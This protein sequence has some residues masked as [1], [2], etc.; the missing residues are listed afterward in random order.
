M[1]ERGSGGAHG[2]PGP[3][4]SQRPVRWWAGAGLFLAAATLS[5]TVYLRAPLPEDDPLRSTLVVLPLVAAAL[6]GIG[7]WAERLG[8]SRR[9]ARATPA[10]LAGVLL[11]TVLALGRSAAGWR[12][13]QA[14]A[15]VL[16]AAFCLLLAVRV[17]R[18]IVALRPA[19]GATPPR[20]PSGLFFLLPLVVY[21]A[22]LPWSTEQRPPDGDEPWYLLI[23]HS[24]AYDFDSRLSNNY[25]QGDSLRFLDRR[26]A[27]QL[28]DPVAEDG[29]AY[30]RHNLTL[31][32][33]LALPY[34]VAGK[35]GALVVMAVLAAAL[36]RETLRLARHYRPVSPRAALLVWAI[37]AFT[38]P[39]LL[40]S[41]QVWVEVP[42]AL[43]LV[44]ALERIH[45]L[46]D[47]EA[48]GLAGWLVLGGCLIAL[49][50]LK[51]RLAFLG[52]VLMAL[53][54]LAGLR[55]LRRQVLVLVGGFALASA[56]V[57][58]VNQILFGNP[59]R[60]YSLE[61][62]LALYQVPPLAYLRGLGGFFF[63]GA[64]G[65][66]P[67]APIWLLLLV[68]LLTAGRHRRLLLDVGMLCLPYLGLFGPH[69]G[70]FGGWSPPFRYALVTLPL[71]AIL[72]IPAL[73]ES[74][75]RGRRGALS[76]LVAL[77]GAL[78]LVWLALPGWTYNLAD[79]RSHLLDALSRLLGA[80]VARFFASYIW[81]RPA[82]WIWPLAAVAAAL[83][84]RWGPRWRRG[85]GRWGPAVALGA[86]ALLPVAAE[87]V[88]SRV[89]ELEDP[90]VAKNGGRL[91][92]HRWT[93]NR[94]RLRSGWLLG[95]GGRVVAPL[96]P[97]G[98]TLDLTVELGVLRPVPS[99]ELLIRQGEELRRRLPLESAGWRSVE[100]GPLPW[101]AGEPLVL[102]VDASP[103]ATARP[104][105]VLDRARLRWLPPQAAGVIA[106]PPARD[107]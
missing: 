17:V 40:Y 14:A 16:F 93:P 31:P 74:Q 34:R 49:P 56:T 20:N 26:L 21:L 33:L 84:W 89:V 29:E 63:D 70:W 91:H 30:S 69:T 79:G 50:L 107:R 62:I 42:A 10:E 98:E 86:M 1:D 53:L 87:T 15:S 27:P 102:E 65:L 96:V 9:Y 23:T 61:A 32:L 100:I 64:F 90:F 106:R 25:E 28:G 83:L 67:Y 47:G 88:P 5:A 78:S 92:P 71:L 41:Y 19:L 103:G 99:L 2:R 37:C 72:M 85:A 94:P 24:L 18:L 13:E 48:L 68:G 73:A 101:A 97:G 45:R 59:L 60:Y 46:R 36:A 105:V 38:P 57:L 12:Y 52:V 4:T 80:D 81:L 55:R 104:L 22:V 3:A 7:R 58:V 66:I 35:L 44:V 77:T 82:A 76:A 43:L 54:L 39:L 75:R 6:A 95:R 11:L 51:F 8:G